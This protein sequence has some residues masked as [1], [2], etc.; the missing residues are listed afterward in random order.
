[1]TIQPPLRRGR[2]VTGPSNDVVRGHVDEAAAFGHVERH[3][4]TALKATATFPNA[5]HAPVEL[6]LLR[7]LPV[8]EVH[9]IAEAGIRTPISR[10]RPRTL[11]E[12]ES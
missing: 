7:E 10:A 4:R 1:M 5:E 9:G 2:A 3:L 12:V 6:V 8:A 11:T